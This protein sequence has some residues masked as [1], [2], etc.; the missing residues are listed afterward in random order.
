[1]LVTIDDRVAG[2]ILHVAR[3]K[4]CNRPTTST[5]LADYCGSTPSYIRRVLL[6][7]SKAGRIR[8]NTRRGRGGGVVLGVPEVDTF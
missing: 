3:T 1:M 6:N 4:F 7:L 8:M 5:E 2:Q